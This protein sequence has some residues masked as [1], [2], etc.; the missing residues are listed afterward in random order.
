MKIHGAFT[1]VLAAWFVVA[2]SA[3]ESRWAGTISDS[4]GV[5][6]VS[7]TDVGIWAAGEECTLEE[8]L[9]IGALEG[10]AEYQ[11]GQVGEISVDSKGFIY[12]LDSQA[13]HIQ[14]YSPDGEYARTVGTRGG[15]PGELQAGIALLMGPGDTL[16][17]PDRQNL[18]FN[19]YAP[20]GSSAGSTKMVIEEGLPLR[21]RATASGMIAEQT[22]PLMLPNQPAIENPEDAIVRLDNDGTI[23]DTLTTFPSGETIGAVLY[24]LFA[25]EP[26]WDVTDE[27]QLVFGVNDEYR[28]ETYSGAQLER[29]IAK[30]FERRPVADADKEA[31]RSEIRRRMTQYGASAEQIFPSL[32]RIHFAEYFPAFNVIV[33][34]P[35]GT[36]W[37]Q[38]VLPMSEMSEGELTSIIDPEDF[39]APDWDVFDAQGRYL[40]VVEM[41]QGFTPRLFRG[42][43]IYGVWHDE[44]DVQYVLRLRIVGDLGPGAT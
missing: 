28:I 4:A 14:V 34:G 15:G 3:G 39:G 25:P 36:I 8:E 42:A 33:A 26:V 9:R 10:A 35:L 1:I 18:R 30:P 29:I 2:C 7:N 17:V 11:F 24:T 23:T 12:V 6:I 19:R 27:L 38:H 20:D 5:T 32:S 40:G 22:R 43:K 16:L 41:P 21:F 37:V 13:Q 31:F 44:L